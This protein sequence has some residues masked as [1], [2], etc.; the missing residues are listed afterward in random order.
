MIDV[1]ILFLVFYFALYRR[2]YKKYGDDPSKSIWIRLFKRYEGSSFDSLFKE[3]QKSQVPIVKCIFMAGAVQT[4]IFVPSF[5][6][7]NDIWIERL[8]S[9]YLKESEASLYHGTS[10]FCVLCTP[11][12]VPA[13]LYTVE[14][15]KNNPE[16]MFV[17]KYKKIKKSCVE[18]GFKDRSCIDLFRM[19]NNT[20]N[21]EQLNKLSKV[22][23]D[24]F[25]SKY[26]FCQVAGSA[27]DYFFE[28]GM[29]EKFDY[30]GEKAC[31]FTEDKSCDFGCDSYKN[32]K[33][34][35]KEEIV[36]R[37]EWVKELRKAQGEKLV[38]Y[39]WRIYP[40]PR[41]FNFEIKEVDEYFKKEM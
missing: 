41:D 32:R 19:M 12:V 17:Y 31:L 28:R 24:S 34:W 4:L 26:F 5:F 13:L 8:G 18:S 37:F 20:E 33:S 22:L 6:Y 15:R 39:T 2:M 7:L 9:E 38:D 25:E 21:A 23:L 40:I 3:N 35:G 36:E 14:W 10:I 27:S 16:E 30:F 29:W 11:V 1:L